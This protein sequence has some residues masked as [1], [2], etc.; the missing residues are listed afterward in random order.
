MDLIPQLSKV[1]SLIQQEEKQHQM[2]PCT[3]TP[4]LMALLTENTFITFRPF[5]RPYCLHY[6]IQRH[7]LKDRFKVGNV[8]P[9]TYGHCHISGHLGKKCYKLVGQYPSHKLRNKGNR[10]NMHISQSNMIIIE[11]FS[12]NHTNKMTLIWNQYQKILQLLHKTHNPAYTYSHMPHNSTTLFANF[13][14]LPSMSG[15]TTCLSIYTH[16]PFDINN[17]PYI[18]DT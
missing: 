4:K 14:S 15:I 17:V 8:K 7:F 5:N 13:T 1:F 3:P 11:D 2:L 18:I 9:P 12:K 10:S 16:K 6:K